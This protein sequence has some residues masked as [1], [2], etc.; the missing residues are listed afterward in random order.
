MGCA[1][2]LSA[3]SPALLQLL[4]LLLLWGRFRV[5]GGR[6]RA[7]LTALLLEYVHGASS[8]RFRVFFPLYVRQLNWVSGWVA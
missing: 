7:R 6:T 2:G 3:L 8:S 4:L 1:L 5:D